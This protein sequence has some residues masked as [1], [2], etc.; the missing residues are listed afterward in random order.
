MAQPSNL[1]S[2][3]DVGFFPNATGNHHEDLSDVQIILGSTQCPAFA[4]FRKGRAKDVVV[5]WTVDALPSTATA[6]S[7]E[8]KTFSGEALAAPTRLINTTQIFDF[9]VVVSDRERD[10][11]PAGPFRD[12]YDKQ[13]MKAFKAITRNCES[14]IFRIATASADT[15]NASASGDETTAPAMGGIDNFN[16]VFSA[17]SASGILTADVTRLSTS[18]FNSGVEPDSI[19][20][21]PAHKIQFFN[22]V[23]SSAGGNGFVNVRNIA[24]MDNRFQANVEIMETPLGQVYAIVVDRFI[25]TATGSGVAATKAGYYIMDRSMAELCFY[26]QP[27]H[28]QM[29]KRGDYT[30][31]LVLMELTVKLDHPSAFG[32]VT[33]VTAI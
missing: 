4:T 5:S 30:E 12:Q 27:Q 22:Q 13:I 23:I 16:I 17:A 24:A 19:W 7:V 25:P 29:G 18:M 32:K 9:G 2:T 28:K 11:N 8:G 1:F 26:R 3:Y 15:T 20:F 31:G 21:A 33:G 10:A 6:G 14:S